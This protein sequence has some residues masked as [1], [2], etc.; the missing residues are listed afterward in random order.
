MRRREFITLLGGAAA[1]WPLAVRAQQP[2]VPVVGFLS[3]ESPSQFTHS[4]DGSEILILR[5]VVM[6]RCRYGRLQR[7]ADRCFIANEGQEV[8]GPELRSWCFP[9]AVWIERR[10]ITEYERQS[11]CRAA[12]SIGAYRV[13]RQMGGWVWRLRGD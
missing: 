1:A 2:A 11:M 9:R 7:Q 10:P 6:F 8:S 4:A 13:R 5:L 3:L 12:K